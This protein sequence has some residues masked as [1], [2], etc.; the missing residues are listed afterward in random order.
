[1]D[2]YFPITKKA[3]PQKKKKIAKIL[4]KRSMSY[5]T[6]FIIKRL[7]P[8]HYKPVC[9]FESPTKKKSIYCKKSNRALSFGLWKNLFIITKTY[10]RITNSM[11]LSKP[12]CF[13]FQPPPTPQS[14][15][16][17]TKLL[18]GNKVDKTNESSC[19]TKKAAGL[20]NST[21]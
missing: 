9:N 21:V 4:A 11:H 6:S 17:I 20:F 13:C 1:M 12:T 7:R 14:K 18:R 3:E 16:G 5:H 15:R 8:L 2:L 10:I 19:C